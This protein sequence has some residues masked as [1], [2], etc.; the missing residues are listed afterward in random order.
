[1]RSKTSIINAIV[2][3][4]MYIVITLA[5]FLTHRIFVRTLGSEYI[6]LNG[7]FGNILS[8]L[9]IVELGF[10]AAVIYNLYKPIAD[11]DEKKINGL[12]NFYKKTYNY[13][14]LI[15]L[16]L[17]LAIL[18]FLNYVVGTVTIKESIHFL[19]VLAL[20][21]VVVSYLLSYKRSI[22][23]ANQQTYI[24]N[25]VHIGY[26]LF[27]NV[28]EIIFLLET[29][30]YSIYLIIKIIFRILENIVITIIANKMYPFIKKRNKEKIDNET[31][32]EIK[33]KVKGLLFHKVGGAIVFGTDNIIISKFLGV[34]T[35][36]L[37]SNYFLII[38]AITN[39]LAQIFASIVSIVG[40]LLLEDNKEKNYKIYKNFLLIN[41][42]LYMF[43]GS[44][45]LCLMEPFISLWIGE[46]YIL[47]HI[48]LIVL[49]INFYIQGMRKT[50]TVFKNAAGIFYEDR[51]VP[52]FE[53]LLNV[54]IS[55][56][57]VQHLGLV[58]VFVGTIVS[59]IIVYLYSFPKFVYKKLFD[60]SYI[61]Y[62][63]EMVKYF[64]ITFITV[65]I[66]A[67]F[68]NITNVGISNFTELIKNLAICLIIPNLIYLLV[69]YRTDEFKYFKEIC[70]R[71]I[72]TKK[73]EE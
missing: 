4:I 28:F 57:L 18:P 3:I 7:L 6:G 62:M 5:N 67:Y 48:V 47:E 58:G 59:T 33:T 38:D 8:M 40:N 27:V 31:K 30:N 39:L 61:K 69:F 15:I 46:W 10:G 12:M 36:G 16:V 35:V 11:K 65:F 9:A 20:I 23:Y 55:V 41:S 14:A 71:F 45:L 2:V 42:W 60:R 13:I 1:M 72:K 56:I 54:I 73:S 44:C 32:I 63:L 24:V 70:I 17:G 25:I 52:V 50:A 66:T 53:A 49:V 51:Y 68:A 43:C 34:V 26:A 21:D 22:L 19:F 29:K 37:Y 64:F